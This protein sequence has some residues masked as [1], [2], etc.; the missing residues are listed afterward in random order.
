MKVGIDLVLVK[1][2]SKMAENIDSCTRVFTLN[3]IEY[4]KTKIGNIDL[5]VKKY[6][7]I[8]YT[9]AGIYA[10][11]EAV[12]KAFGVGIAKEI[13]ITDIEI[14]HNCNGACCVNLLG[15]AKQFAKDHHFKSIELSVSHDGEYATAICAII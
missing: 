15:K 2:F 4:I 14:T 7:P 6:K 1:R 10:S 11:K 5:S 12:L 9:I 3:E 8:E 13:N